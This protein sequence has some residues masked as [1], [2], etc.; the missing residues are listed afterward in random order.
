[1]MCC[2]STSESRKMRVAIMVYTAER[3]ALKLLRNTGQPGEGEEKKQ[4][5]KLKVREAKERLEK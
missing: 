3:A 5:G 4:L 1:M 2:V